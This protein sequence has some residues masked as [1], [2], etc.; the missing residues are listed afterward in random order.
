MRLQDIQDT[1]KDENEEARV[2]DPIS[3]QER[4]EQVNN[5]KNENAPE[6]SGTSDENHYI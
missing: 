4:M 5:Q 2:S 6:A 1:D 3:N